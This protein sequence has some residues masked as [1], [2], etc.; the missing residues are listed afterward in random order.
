MIGVSAVDEEARSVSLQTESEVDVVTV[1]V[2]NVLKAEFIEFVVDFW[3]GVLKEVLL[4]LEDSQCRG[5][6][7]A[8]TVGQSILLS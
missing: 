8:G 5:S 6:E 2:G 4:A 3:V 7:A 1:G